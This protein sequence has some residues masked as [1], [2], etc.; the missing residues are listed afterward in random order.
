M[1]DVRSRFLLGP[2]PAMAC[3]SENWHPGSK[4]DRSKART[5]DVRKVAPLFCLCFPLRRGSSTA[6]GWPE[7][8]SVDP[9][10]S[11]SGT[12]EAPSLKD[13]GGGGIRSTP[14]HH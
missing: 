4:H 9:N 2:A 6:P 10:H 1:P 7:E 8:S 14:R 3:T 5:P 11:G 12:A 13:L